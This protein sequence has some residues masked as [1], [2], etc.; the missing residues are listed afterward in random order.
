M[1]TQKI[2]HHQNIMQKQ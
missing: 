1:L 2:S